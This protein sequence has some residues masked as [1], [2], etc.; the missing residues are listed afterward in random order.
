M[1]GDSQKKAFLIL[2]VFISIA[3]VA[4]TV[5]AF[6]TDNWVNFDIK[7]PNNTNTSGNTENNEL[8]ANG[9]F[10]LFQG[11]Q[12]INYGFGLRERLTKVLCSEG[13]CTYYVYS[14]SIRDREE[15]TD[16]IGKEYLGRL[17]GNFTDSGKEPWEYGIF[18]MGYRISI[19]VMLAMGIVWGLVS[20]GFTVYNIFGKPI[21]TITGP[22]GLY[23]WNLCA[24]VFMVITV[25]LFVVLFQT[26]FSKNVLPHEDYPKFKPM[27]NIN[28]DYSFF[29]TVAALLGYL[30][31]LVLLMC[32]GYQIRCLCTQEANKAMDNG[33][34]LY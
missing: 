9:F 7:H 29:L 24:L 17:V 8:V 21:E 14:S 10:G 23:M 5:A 15:Y 13:W 18:E 19:L 34:I 12:N 25:I 20:I 1:A 3:A 28:L 26:N 22:L 4:L 32:S 33:I 27:D 31:N 2:T 30:I 16:K 11:E 6:A